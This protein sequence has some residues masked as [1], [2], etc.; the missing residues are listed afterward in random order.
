MTTKYIKFGLRADKNLSDL[1]NPSSALSNLLNDVS[2]QVDEF[3][4]ATG[5]TN[6][7]IDP[8][9]GLRN[10]GLADYVNELGQST[11]LASLN[12]SEVLYTPSAN[13]STQYEVEPRITI[14][15]NINN[16]RSVLGD[17]PWIDGGEGP[18]T[19]FVT[20]DRINTSITNYTNGNSSAV[21]VGSLGNNLF[22][23][24][25]DPALYPIIG[26]LDFWNNGVFELSS[27]L[28]P[29]FPNTY[30]LIQWTGY[31]SRNFV[32]SWESTG[33]FMIEEDVVDDGTEN[34][35]NT[36]KSVWTTSITLSSIGKLNDGTNTILTM[37]SYE[38]LRKEQS[39]HVCK[40]MS[41]TI[42]GTDYI[43]DSF[44]EE[45]GEAII[46][47]PI[48]T[49]YLGSTIPSLTFFWSLSDD[50]I[51]TGQIKL[52]EP[53]TGGRIRARYTVWWP[54]PADIGLSPGSTY[55]TKR[56]AYSILSSERLPFSQFY[57]TYDRNQVFGEYS[58]KYFYD[59][60]A[61]ALSQRSE[62]PVRVNNTFSMNYISPN[63]LDDVVIGMSPGASS[64]ANRTITVGDKYGRLE[65]DFSGCVVGDWLAWKMPAAGDPGVEFVYQIQ[66]LRSDNI[67]YVKSDME[68][69]TGIVVGSTF[70]TLIFK[71]LGLIGIY[72][73]SSAGGTTG[74]LYTLNGG[75]SV[76]EVYPDY[77][78]VGIEPF[79]S[80]G[81]QPLR[82]LSVDTGTNP[83]N[84]VVSDYLSNG[85]SLNVGNSFAAVYASSGLEDL[86]SAQQCGGVYGREVVTTAGSGATTITL[87][88]TT[89]VTNGDYAQ[90]EG[91]GGSA[92]PVI[93][94]GT[95]VTVLNS[96]QISLSTGIR[97]GKTLNAAA[98][99]VF[100]KSA[101]KG[102]Y[103]TDNKEYCV[104][105]LNTAPPFEGTA[106]GL[107]TS[108]SNPNLVVTGLTFGELDVTVPASKIVDLATSP[109][110]NNRGD[111]SFPISYNGTVYKTLINT[112]G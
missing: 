56:F 39:K 63:S 84:V 75:V 33:L 101:N 99:V 12:G 100:I 79:G 4:S 7:D 30:G 47:E 91:L 59:N 70:E 111:Q 15:D 102:A 35:W 21:A 55:R 74:S 61:S 68:T 18:L 82:V 1:G 81:T 10:T 78:L 20:S 67:A 106:L 76:T 3:G 89:G 13:P 28:H 69:V 19:N 43:I 71:N 112:S 72:R 85:A 103:G 36:I 37:G 93:V 73:I 50:L 51:T 5:F 23:T 44:D 80:D 95:T 83:K 86:S 42:S 109:L 11:D 92:D 60:K 53:R 16:F 96:T 48:G 107:S 29:D 14:Q 49:P 98:T 17:P 58:Y 9:I 6:T 88:T 22:S 8:I 97:A 57:S 41:V 46:A 54:D 25:E 52:T 108:T 2:A 32:Q 26:P 66:E 104:I 90:Y 31:L 64:V 34:N 65:G 110:T 87:A 38:P 94:E 24:L 45:A 27:K 77:I 40:G 62:S 105:P